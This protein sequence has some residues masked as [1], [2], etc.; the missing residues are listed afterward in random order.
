[1]KCHCGCVTLMKWEGGGVRM[2]RKRQ[3][4]GEDPS[5]QESKDDWV[6]EDNCKGVVSVVSSSIVNFCTW[7]QP[8]SS[9]RTSPSS[10]SGLLCLP[11]DGGGS[12]ALLPP[13]HSQTR[14]PPAHQPSTCHNTA[15]KVVSFPDQPHA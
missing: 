5:D 14:L 12:G 4:Q 1:M 13:S 7:S 6:N 3:K 2:G 15:G 9:S 11:S 8:F 10:R